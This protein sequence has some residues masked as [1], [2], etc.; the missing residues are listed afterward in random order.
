MTSACTQCIANYTTSILIYK[1]FTFLFPVSFHGPNKCYPKILWHGKSG[2]M[3]TALK[4]H[5]MKHITYFPSFLLLWTR[6]Y[7]LELPFHLN[8]LLQCNQAF[9]SVRLYRTACISW[10]NLNILRCQCQNL[11]LEMILSQFK[12][13]SI[14]ICLRSISVTSSFL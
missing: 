12:Q 5:V 2:N 6:Y 1:K 9:I 11:P 7:R 13:V 14:F 10:K 8:H 3:I 4:V